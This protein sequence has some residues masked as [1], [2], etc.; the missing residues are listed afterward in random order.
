MLFIVASVVLFT[1]L[2]AG[3]GGLC[4]RCLH[5]ATDNPWLYP[6]LGMFAAGTL[7]AAVSMFLPLNA[8]ALAVFVLIGLTGLP[9]WGRMLH[10]GQLGHSRAACG[11]FWAFMFSC[12]LVLAALYARTEWP[13]WAYDTDLYHANVVRWI[14]EYGT[15]P[16]LANLHTRFG[17]NSTW[18]SLSALF[19]NGYWDNRIAWI[20]PSL[21]YTCTIAYLSY[22]VL[23]RLG[24]I[25]RLFCGAML[26]FV[27]GVS[28]TSSY[29]SLY[30]DL[31]ALFINIA[32]FA[33][34]LAQAEKG[35]EV[36]PGQASL[37]ICLAALSFA[38]KPLTGISLFFA[39]AVIL[40]GVKKNSG[41]SVAR[42]CGVFA[43][44]VAAGVVWVA[45]NALLSGYPLFPL[46]LWPLPLEWTIPKGTAV[47]TYAG[48]IGWARMPGLGYEQ[49]L[50]TWDWI[51]PW[52]ERHLES[53][54]FWCAA[55]LPLLASIPLWIKSLCRNEYKAPS[56]FGAWAALCLL[57]WFITAPSLRFGAV[58]FQIFFALGL[59]FALSQT[60]RI[61]SWEAHCA[62][63]LRNR[64]SC[65]LTSA[66]LLLT[67]IA[68]SAGVLLAAKSKRDVLYVGSIPSREL[69][70]RVFDASVSPQILLFF[71]AGDDDRCGNSP[72]PC[73]PSD[74]PRLKL[75]VPG[76]LGGGFYIQEKQ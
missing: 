40:Y 65:C 69:S 1:C 34:C 62:H 25:V 74:N 54:A 22:I 53:A 50:H 36:T 9:L 31:P 5:F 64:R 21:L 55:G 59:A 68:V 33:E 13:G 45:R 42:A 7:F 35:W 23:F 37:I 24:N 28:I 14:N 46:P 11:M 75:R 18:L 10:A 12:V 16:G 73:A 52:L 39:A 3:W 20:M 72:L 60:P 29:P 26:L 43:P 38:M 61:A 47:A 6:F 44:A 76:N 67:A 2:L 63:L 8:V 58:F 70:S 19:D 17:K 41:L 71:P 15:P 30:Y 32:V 27:I 51:V 57:Y 66:V 56:F 48:V 4:V 49:F